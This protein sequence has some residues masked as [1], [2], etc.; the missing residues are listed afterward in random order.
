MKH[1]APTL[2]VAGLALTVIFLP[3]TTPASAAQAVHAAAATPTPVPAD[4]PTPTPIPAV[5]PASIPDTTHASANCL[6][7]H[8]DPNFLGH[9]KNSDPVKLFV[10]PNIYYRSLHAQIGLECA[11]C[12]AD[13]RGYPH[14]DTGQVACLDCHQTFG[15]I[16]FSPQYKSLDVSLNFESGRSLTLK[17][18]E[19]CKS[20]HTDEASQGADSVH[21]KVRV[22]GNADAPVCTDC[23]GSHDLTAPDVPR[24]KI[25]QTCAKCH[26]SVYTTYR[27]SV[28][29]EALTGGNPDVP[30]CVDCHGVHNVQGPSN[31]R[32]RDSMIA[33]CGSCHS[34]PKR[35]GKYHIATDVFNTYLDDFHGR[36]VNFFRTQDP[37]QQSNKA[38]CIDC[39]GVHNIL[40]PDNP[41]ST[42]YPS[43]LQQT[44]QQCH[45]QASIR[46]PQAWLGHY[47]PTWDKTPV[48]FAVNLG[49]QGFIPLTIG[50]FVIY[51]GLDA[52]RR[53][54]GKLKAAR[55]ADRDDQNEE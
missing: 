32:F 49:Y 31:P 42:V 10:D 38:T 36:T 16:G 7:C 52:Q 29:G 18:N 51:I 24:A 40:P 30:T 14:T 5:P 50:G 47:V 15:G 22:E 39:H 12:H 1:L 17:L 41:Q 3:V 8:A 34:D 23:H 25:S 37:M 53:I 27:S 45:P 13:Q 19:N 9:A 28:H 26:L 20:C 48:L 44:C 21:T 6:M 4:S 35:M 11:A 33:V 2:I 55:R 46:F 54:R 43:N